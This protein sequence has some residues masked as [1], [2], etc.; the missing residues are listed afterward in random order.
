[1]VEGLAESHRRS[2][3]ADVAEVIV[4]EVRRLLTDCIRR[5]PDGDYELLYCFGTKDCSVPEWSNEAGYLF[6]W[7]SSIAYAYQIS[8][9]SFFAKW[10]DTLFTYGETKMRER[11]DIRS[12]T[13]VLSFPHLFVE[14]SPLLARQ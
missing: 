13:S 4:G 10:A 7:L 11:Y 5:R 6:L 1:M 9:D 8:H 14:A 3:R 12:W 2:G